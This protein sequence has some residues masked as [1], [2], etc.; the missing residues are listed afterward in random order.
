MTWLLHALDR[1][2]RLVGAVAVA[3][4]AS[5]L[6]L[7]LLAPTGSLLISPPQITAEQGKAFLVPIAPASS[8]FFSLVGD[9][10]GAD[11][12]S[13]LVLL[14][15]G[16]P[17]GPAHASHESIR[18][19]GA[20]R[21][22]HWGSGLWFST[23]DSSDPRT[24]GRT[25][26]ADFRMSL[27]PKWKLRG[28]GLL[29]IGA[30]ALIAGS[31]RRVGAQA[32]GAFARVLQALARSG[33]ASRLVVLAS[34]A[35]GAVAGIAAVIGG[36][37][38]GGTSETGLAIARFL[39][40]SDAFG[41]HSCATAISVTGSFDQPFGGGWCSRRALYPALLASL[42]TLI[43]WSSQAALIA[44]GALVGAAVAAFASQI[45]ERMGGASAVIAAVL[46]VAYAWEFV[47][48][49][50]MTEVAGLVFGLGGLALLLREGERGH[51]ARIFV[52]IACFSVGM[53]ARAGALFALPALI[54]WAALAFPGR[55][56]VQRV[57]AAVVAIA[58]V[59]VGPVLQFLFV[60]RLGSDPFHT[61]SNFGASL[62]GLST[63]SRDWTEAY[64]AFDHLFRVSEGEAF[65]AAYRAALDNIQARPDVFLGA[66]AEA[67]SAYL[68]A[69]FVFGDLG[70]PHAA[71]SVLAGLGLVRC[72]VA[73]R[74]PYASLLI[75]LALAEALAAPLIFDSGGNRVFA[76]TIGVRILLAALSVQWILQL[77]SGPTAGVGPSATTAVHRDFNALLP[78]LVLGLMLVAVTPLSTVFRPAPVA[79]ATCEGQLE[80][81]V[82]RVGAESQAMRWTAGSPAV[83]SLWP[84]VIS[85][86]RLQSDQRIG[87]TWFGE[88]FLAVE[89]TTTVVRAVDLQA[90]RY[91]TIHPLIIE[92]S[93]ADRGLAVLCVD[94]SKGR[95]LAGVRHFAV[96]S[97]RSDGN[98]R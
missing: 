9:G 80:A 51:S 21:Y 19:R 58:A 5:V 3:L 71:L 20:G 63:G 64:R 84:F 15:D 16:R 6:L 66:L 76:V 90:A 72:L 28:I 31:K 32:I 30:A 91:G 34:V 1:W 94:R 22:A 65:R 48:G 74:Q 38:W 61:G 45:R 82:A 89:P 11:R 68:D 85:R 17:L 8:R 96:P 23:P 13:T 70:L 40:V 42:L 44:Q 83:H 77:A 86:E 25:Y 18:T 47:L 57:R 27:H 81:V 87:E 41:Y 43:G 56:R 29:V 55:S 37:Y 49:L 39:P 50:F 24:N 92:G 67:F 59:L 46:L 75:V 78:A 95:D 69:L 2:G 97:L 36:W 52:G 60:W 33:P 98:R 35:A 93:V 10:V 4:G 88:D 14:E 73:I 26:R 79:A 12:V 54:I 53:T 62:Y 7:S